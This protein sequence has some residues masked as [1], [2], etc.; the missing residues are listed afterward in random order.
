MTGI[1]VHLLQA[2][3]KELASVST[4]KR[5]QIALQEAPM[6]YVSCPAAVI[7]APVDAVWAL[8]I[9]PAAWGGVF[10]ARVGSI[11]P[12]GS[13]IVGQKIS[14]ETGP[15]LLPRSISTNITCLD[16]H[17]PC[18]ITVHE[19]LSCTPLDVDRCRVGYRCNFDFPRGWRGSLA[20]V[21]IAFV[22]FRAFVP[23]K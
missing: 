14:G 13:A 5:S 6:R 20:K 4:K 12:P 1:A 21:L 16:V 23:H 7:N 15:R 11:D 19:D 10:D 17:L 22:P 3:R 9:E 2:G 8:L 18:G